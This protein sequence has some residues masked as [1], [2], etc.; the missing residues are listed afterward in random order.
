MKLSLWI[1][2]AVRPVSEVERIRWRRGIIDGG[3]FVAVV[4]IFGL[5]LRYVSA[6]TFNQLR[7]E[8]TARPLFSGITIFFLVAVVA[9]WVIVER[10]FF[11]RDDTGHRHISWEG[12]Q[13]MR[14]Q[15]LLRRVIRSIPKRFIPDHA[16]YEEAAEQL[17]SFGHRTLEEVKAVA[18]EPWF[19][20]LIL[21]DALEFREGRL[22]CGI[23]IEAIESDTVEEHFDHL[24]SNEED[25]VD[26]PYEVE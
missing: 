20:T 24:L 19:W 15:A 3:L 25:R 5:I 23:D 14:L 6:D 2:Q 1:A 22:C 17:R 11:C 26:A 21:S 18:K 4:L 8:V 10:V 13:E 7:H 9:A 12:V 16:L